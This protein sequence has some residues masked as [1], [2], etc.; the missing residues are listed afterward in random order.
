MTTDEAMSDTRKGWRRATGLLCIVLAMSIL[1]PIVLVV[2][3]LL[4]LLGLE[5]R[6]TVAII[7]ASAFGVF[8]VLAGPRDG[9]WFVERGWAVLAGG[10]FT[11]LAI[12]VPHWRL[13]SRSMA[14][15]G[16][17]IVVSGVFLTLR[18]GAWAAMDWQVTDHLRSG[19]AT[20][21][22]IL[23]VLRD[24]ETVPTTLV[25]AIYQTVEA[26]AAVF[27][28]LV[29]IETMAALG[30]VWWIFG[31]VTQ[32]EGMDLGTVRGFRFNDHLVWLMIVGLTMVALLPGDG[33]SRLGANVAVFMGS[34]YALRGIG[35]V[36]FVNGGLTFFG[37]T[38]FALGILF[39][40]P[41]V[42]GFTVLLGIADTWLD[43]RARAGA[44]A[45]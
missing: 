5:G 45:A 8:V 32:A 25:T 30:L 43:L 41:V 31:R 29:A 12:Y 34:L 16:S 27:P 20:W 21:L 14:A 23:A 36:V 2:V 22:Y 19:F 10:F 9:L 3:P 35:V 28:A 4:I 6:R 11:A 37:I 13:T 39:A 33:V 38:M 24:R 42:I 40:A 17:A 1:Q 44:Q 26:Q 7:V 18:R 15:V